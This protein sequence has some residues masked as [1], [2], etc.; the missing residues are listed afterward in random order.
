MAFPFIEATGEKEALRVKGW[1]RE[2]YLTAFSQSVFMLKEGIGEAG[3]WVVGGMAREAWRKNE[4]F[5]IYTRDKTKKGE[6]RDIDILIGIEDQNTFD[7][8]RKYNDTGLGWGSSFR[9]YLRVGKEQAFLKYGQHRV[10]LPMQVFEPQ[11]VSLG[12]VDFPT[13]FPRT[14]LHMYAVHGAL[15]NKFEDALKLARI[16]KLHPEVDLP[17][18]EYIGFHKFMSIR[19]DLRKNPVGWVLDRMAKLYLR[20]PM[21]KVFSLSDS[22]IMPLIKKIWWGVGNRIEVR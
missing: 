7:E 12:G 19:S 6:L 10:D 16:V 3:W 22:R 20:S 4:D 1:D 8:V 9:W 17:E 21:N 18:S 11:M 5:A 13:V 2:S 15:N 14:L